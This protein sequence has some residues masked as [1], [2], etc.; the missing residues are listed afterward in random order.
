MSDKGR[1]NRG[2]EGFNQGESGRLGDS[3]EKT[4]SDGNDHEEGTNNGTNAN[5]T[6]RRAI[7]EVGHGADSVGVHQCLIPLVKVDARVC[8]RDSEEDQSDEVEEAEQEGDRWH[9]RPFVTLT[10]IHSQQVEQRFEE[11][12]R[13]DLKQ[14]VLNDHEGGPWRAVGQ[15]GTNAH[16]SN[17]DAA[18]DEDC[19]EDVGDEAGATQQ[20]DQEQGDQEE[21]GEH[22]DDAGGEIT[23]LVGNT[24]DDGVEPAEVG[25]VRVVDIRGRTTIARRILSRLQ[26]ARGSAHV[27]EIVIHVT[28]NADCTLSGGGRRSAARQR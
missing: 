27:G 25:A 24:T 21:H 17:H 9:T 20:S 14:D 15:V 18:P 3:Q 2:S 13:Q 8:S 7:G 5:D 28:S 16:G 6:D 10:R 1:D 22:P 23:I 26:E 12:W 4:T 11:K 19:E